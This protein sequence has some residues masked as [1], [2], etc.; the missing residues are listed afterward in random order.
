MNPMA[1]LEERIERDEQGRVR[2]RLQLDGELPVGECLTWD[3]EGWLAQRAT[4]KNGL[5]DGQLIEYDPAGSPVA[6]LHHRAGKLHGQAQFFERGRPLLTTHW[7]DGVQDGESIVYGPDGHPTARTRYRA[8]EL[9]GPASWYRP[10]GL[11][12]RAATYIDGQ[13]EG[14]VLDYDERGRVTERAPHRGGKLHGEVIR[15]GRD[16]AVTERVQFVAGVEQPA[17]PPARRRS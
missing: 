9:H 10:G 14:D 7:Q 15:Y 16:G 13:L 4:F 12:M 11:L 6:I 2:R 8:G 5:L 1:E 17:V 3:A